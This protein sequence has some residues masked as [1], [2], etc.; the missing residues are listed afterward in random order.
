MY[1]ITLYF[2]WLSK[3]T[4][5]LAI[6]SSSRCG[7][8]IVLYILRNKTDLISLLCSPASTFDTAPAELAAG[9]VKTGL[10]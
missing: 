3:R 8:L 9:M 1:G 10:I 7:A 6:L 2:A 4:N 5:L